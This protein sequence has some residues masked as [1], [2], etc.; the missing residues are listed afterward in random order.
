MSGEMNTMTMTMPAVQQRP[1][2]ITVRC[3]AATPANIAML[4]KWKAT[5]TATTTSNGATATMAEAILHSGMKAIELTARLSTTVRHIRM[6]LEHR[7]CTATA[8]N[9]VRLNL[10]AVSR[11]C[12][13]GGGGGVAASDAAADPL[14]SLV[15][16]LTVEEMMTCPQIAIQHG[17]V[18]GEVRVGKTA[19]EDSDSTPSSTLVLLYARDTALGC[20]DCCLCACLTAVCATVLCCCCCN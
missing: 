18:P 17:C 9:D 16:E 20:S 4:R 3:F 5:T 1:V 19:D 14:I 11:G 2:E 7:E 10:F 8:T 15:D 12:G 6:E 13:C